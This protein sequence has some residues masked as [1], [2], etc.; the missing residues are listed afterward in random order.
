MSSTAHLT[1]A[2]KLMGLQVDAPEVTA[3]TAIIQLGAIAATFV[4]FFRDIVRLAAA[5]VAARRAPMSPPAPRLRAGLGGHR[6]VD[7]RRGGRVRA[8]ERHRGPLA[9]PV[10]GRRGPHP[11]E[12]RDVARRGATRQ[13]PARAGRARRGD[14]RRPR[15]ARHRSGQCFSL[16]PGVSR[17]GATISAGL[18][19][20]I[21]RV[22]ATRL[23]F[24][25]SIP[26]LTAA[27]LYEGR[28]PTCR[29]SARGRWG[30]DRRRLRRRVCV[31]RVA[32]AVRRLEH[33]DA[34]RVVPRGP[35]C[36]PRGHPGDGRHHPDVTTAPL[37]ASRT[38]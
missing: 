18:F 8:E 19:R 10:G 13:A 31:D 16:I 35:R 28:P 9:Q 36:G 37:R 14:G 21:D 11:L 6:R 29:T 1:I 22:T 12:R 20:G 3:Y 17:S 15:R 33:P 34:V 27:G 5:W 38:A 23:S 30:R 24:F 2:E 7:P 25:L 4:Y 26:A 32:A